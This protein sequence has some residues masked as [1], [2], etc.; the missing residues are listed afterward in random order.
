LGLAVAL[1]EDSDDVIDVKIDI[2]GNVNSPE[3]SATGLVWQAIRT[4]L[5]NVV[6]AP[7]RALGSLLGMQGDPAIYAI[8]GEAAFLPADQE[9]FTKFS[10]LL[11]KRPHATI[12]LIGTYDPQ[13]DRQELSRARA[14]RAILAASGFKLEANAP[15]PM[16]SLSD[17]RI[18]AGIKSA[19]A[20]EIGRIK[21]AQRIVTLPDNLERYQQLR[22]ELIAHFAVNDA[23]LQALADARAREAREVM[24]KS[25]PTLAERIR[26][27]SPKA[28]TAH[29]EGIP[30]EIALGSK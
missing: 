25:N 6:T 23:Q 12:T 14:D 22:Q 15:L 28:V 19:Y 29:R 24:V 5:T 7:F 16:P 2:A 13:L 18:Q 20:A 11:V 3:F 17:K 21:L 9:H 27:G 1:L 8:A 10:D 30:L 26:L 4:V